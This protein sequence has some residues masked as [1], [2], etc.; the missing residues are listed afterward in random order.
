MVHFL[1]QHFQTLPDTLDQR[2]SIWIC[3][4]QPDCAHDLTAGQRDP[5]Q[6]NA[7][8]Q[9][10]HGDQEGRICRQLLRGDRAHI[11]G[12]PEWHQIILAPDGRDGDIARVSQL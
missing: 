6:A 10:Q 9:V 7:A 12:N 2:Q 11:D 3:V 8:T 1:I 4:Q 5:H